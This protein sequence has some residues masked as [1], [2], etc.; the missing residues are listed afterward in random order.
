M[1]ILACHSSKGHRCGPSASRTQ[2]LAHCKCHHY[3][4]VLCMSARVCVCLSVCMLNYFPVFC[5]IHPCF[6]LFSLSFSMCLLVFL[7]FFLSIKIHSPPPTVLTSQAV[8]IYMYWNP[9][10][11]SMSISVSHWQRSVTFPARSVIG[12]LFSSHCSLFVLSVFP[13][14]IAPIWTFLLSN[15]QPTL[16]LMCRKC[17][18]TMGPS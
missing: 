17:F 3:R 9:I 14:T 5:P 4:S 15:W 16:S 11:R 10:D 12:S 8:N 7:T 6:L 1:V 2:Q 18:I 13:T